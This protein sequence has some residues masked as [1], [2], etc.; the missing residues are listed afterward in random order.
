MSGTVT[1]VLPAY[2][3]SALVNCDDSGLEDEERQALEAWCE[4]ANTPNGP[5]LDVG[6]PYYAR[7]NDAGTLAGD[8]A[9]YL[10]LE[11]EDG[12]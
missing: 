12:A 3:A 2:W 6:E 11:E 7:N 4:R 8:V 1:Y 5:C 9:E 10:F